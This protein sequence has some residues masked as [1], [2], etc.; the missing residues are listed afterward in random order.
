M[1]PGSESSSSIA[2]NVLRYCSTTKKPSI[3]SP[4]WSSNDSGRSWN[5]RS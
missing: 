3:H 1:G 5:E 4:R 2:M